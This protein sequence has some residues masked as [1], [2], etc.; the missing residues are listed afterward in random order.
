MSSLGQMYPWPADRIEKGNWGAIQWY[1][2]TLAEEALWL[3]SHVGLESVGGRYVVGPAG[4]GIY[5]AYETCDLND[6]DAIPGFHSVSSKLHQKLYGCPDVGYRPKKSKEKLAA[7]YAHQ[8]GHCLI[9]ERMD[10]ISGRLTALWSVVP[11]FGTWVP[12]AISSEDQQKALAVWWNST[13]VRMML[14][15][16][17]AKKLTY[18]KW[19]LVHLREVR[20][21]KPDNRAWSSLRVAFDQVQDCELRPMREA[22]Q[23]EARKVIDHAAAQALNLPPDRLRDWRERLSKEPTVNHT[24]P[25]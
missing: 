11:S 1:D 13:P 9:A 23:C 18:P 3:E 7:R 20:I 16:R 15:N 14:L 19:S 12:V 6:P 21:P 24:I 8:R 10:T 2:G 25:E 22:S 17:R 4:R 5:D